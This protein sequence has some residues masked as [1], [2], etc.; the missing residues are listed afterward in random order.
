[1]SVDKFLQIERSHRRVLLAAAALVAA[2]GLYSW[3]LSPH[4]QQ[5]MA[6]E[7]YNSTLDKAIHKAGFMN[8]LEDIKKGKIEELITES[9]RQRNQLFTMQEMRRFWASLPNVLNQSGCVIQSVS[10]VPDS[11]P[12][13][14]ANGSGIA[15]KKAVVTFTGGYNDVIKFLTAIQDSEQKVW[16]ESV[17]IDAGTAGKLKCKLLLTLYCVERAENNLYE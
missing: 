3:I 6:A 7:R 1:M 14:Q 11:Q 13:A 2:F 4:T 12:A 5:L 17:K 10:A 8:N 15:A 9:R 16:I